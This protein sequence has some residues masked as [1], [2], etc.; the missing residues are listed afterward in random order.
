MAAGT[1]LAAPSPVVVSPEFF[2]YAGWVRPRNLCGTCV[3][4]KSLN[5]P[6]PRQTR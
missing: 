4:E 2:V 1:N 5:V 3:A 6:F